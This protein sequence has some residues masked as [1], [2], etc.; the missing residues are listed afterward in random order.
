[1]IKFINIIPYI[2]LIIGIFFVFIMDSRLLRKKPI[3]V[4]KGTKKEN[5]L[6]VHIKG[7]IYISFE[8]Q[9]KSIVKAFLGLVVILF[10]TTFYLTLK[11]GVVYS[12]IV[13]TLMASIPYIGLVA[14]RKYIRISV[15]YDAEI[16]ITEL[17]NQYKINSENMITALERTIRNVDSPV[18]KKI[19]TRLTIKLKEYKSDKEL[20][21]AI[22][23][24]VYAIDTEWAKMLAN[25]LY[26]SINSGLDVTNSLEDIV[27]EL[28]IAKSNFE[29]TDRL[30]NENFMIGKYLT[31]M[32]YF[33]SIYL[34]IDFFDYTLKEFLHEQFK[35]SS[36]INYFII[37]VFLTVININ[38]MYYIKNR[39]FDF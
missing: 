38:F 9:S 13:S 23:E 11:S 8:K 32:L 31:P 36:G 35:T 4:G 22:D 37:I 15:S 5:K 27:K 14:R 3:R 1:M 19:L 16:I 10:S 12:V 17:V 39:K 26:L 24:F 20:H 25:N 7:L 34:A 30:N 28:I 21:L 2:L 29:K 6:Y 33:G 18:S